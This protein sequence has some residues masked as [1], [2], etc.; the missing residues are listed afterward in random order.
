MQLAYRFAEGE[1]PS[2][3]PEPTYDFAA[4]EYVARQKRPCT[5]IVVGSPPYNSHL[6]Y[7]CLK[8]DEKEDVVPGE[9]YVGAKAYVPPEVKPEASGLATVVFL[10]LAG[11]LLWRVFSD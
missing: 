10:G 8:P 5:G 9:V 1:F 6:T 11:L 3:F 2:P 7:D 4:D